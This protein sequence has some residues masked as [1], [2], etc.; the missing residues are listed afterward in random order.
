MPKRNGVFTGATL[1]AVGNVTKLIIQVG[2]VP[3][4]ARLLGPEVYGLIAFSTA[5]ITF[6]SLLGET[7]LSGAIGRGFVTS[8]ESESTVF[9][10]SVGCGLLAVIGID[11]ASLIIVPEVQRTAIVPIVVALNPALI[12]SAIASLPNGL[13]FREQKFWAFALADIISVVF[14]LAVAWVLA[15][16]GFGVWSLV[17]QINMVFLLKFAVLWISAKPM[18]RL[19]FDLRT[20]HTIVPYGVNAVLSNTATFLSRSVD[21][22]IVAASLGARSLGFYAMGFQLVT[23]PS[24]IVTSPITGAIFPLMGRR[25]H[26]LAEV[27][28]LFLAV[29]SFVYIA[30]FP[31]F[32]GLASVS[33]LVI[34]VFF[35]HK[36][37]PTISIIQKLCPYAFFDAVNGTVA[38]ALLA[39]G[40]SREQLLLSCL[41]AVLTVA[42]VAI[43]VAHGA[44]GVA[45]GMICAALLLWPFY[46]WQAHRHLASSVWD[47]LSR[48]MRP[49]LCTLAMAAAVYGTRTAGSI[50]MPILRLLAAAA[51][52]AVAYIGCAALLCRT[53][54]RDIIQLLRQR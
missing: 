16:K 26:D 38:A 46:L 49:G 45:V 42:T 3:I 24:W 37:I 1:L 48:L 17:A 11:A 7:G 34:E 12:L 41:S 6:G 33:D 28:A 22:V 4:L 40:R 15:L 32:T 19:H 43:G 39:V 35:D 36:W 23:M 5:L 51:A 20:I 14:G 53:Q 8:V 52:G 54:I 18:V 13:I 44:D 50:E 9:W 10:L 27:R 2:S 47:S 29:L 30:A 25:S 21:N 31:I